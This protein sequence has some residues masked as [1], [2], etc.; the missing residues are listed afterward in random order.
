LSNVVGVDFDYSDNKLLYTQIRPFARIAW[1]PSRSPSKESSQVILQKGVNPEGIAYDWTHRKIYWT[2]SSNNSIYAMNLDG[3]QLVMI[4]RVER[5]RAIVLDPCNGSLYYTDWGRFGTS[6]KIYR[7]S[8]AGSLKKA[9]VEKE[10]SQ[11]SGLAIDYEERMLYWTDA[12]REK[13]ERATLDGDRREVLISATIYPFA[14]T[15]H[16]NYIYWTDLQLRGVY[17]AEKH[18]GAN[19]VEMVKRL[20]DSPRDIHVFSASRQQCSVNA[21]KINNGG[22]QQSCHPGPNN[23]AECRCDE[24]SKLVN[25]D[26]MCVPK[27]ITCDQVSKKII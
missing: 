4:A 10:L 26:R 24:Q 8:M 16:G 7:T 6:G 14:I 27:N 21:C 17:R 23:T 5:P 2:D 11:P 25:E 20:E 12:V 15:V 3:S 22:C 18:T 19:L 13:I 1:M 9:I